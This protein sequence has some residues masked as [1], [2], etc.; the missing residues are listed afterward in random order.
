MSP[1]SLEPQPDQPQSLI[2]SLEAR[3]LCA[4]GTVTMIRGVITIAPPSAM[5]ELH[6]DHSHP[7]QG[8]N[9]LNTAEAK[10]NGVVTWDPT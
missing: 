4:R 9:G 7:A 10:S 8:V 1:F 5:L 6:I 3:L 2:E